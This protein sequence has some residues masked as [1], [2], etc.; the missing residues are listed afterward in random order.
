MYMQVLCYVRYIYNHIYCIFAG[1]YRNREEFILTYDIEREISPD[2]PM[3]H[4]T[5]AIKELRDAVLNQQWEDVCMKLYQSKSL[6][7]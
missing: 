1:S 7:A 6:H 5:K 3:H 4:R 2:S